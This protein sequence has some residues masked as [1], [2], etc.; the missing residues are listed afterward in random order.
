MTEDSALEVAQAQN[1]ALEA[2]IVRRAAQADAVLTNCIESYINWLNQNPD[3]HPL[4]NLTHHLVSTSVETAA[5]IR[6]RMAIKW[7]GD[8]DEQAKVERSVTNSLRRSAGTNYQALVSYALAR[9]LLQR[10]SH[11]YVMHPVPPTFAHSLA[12]RFGAAIPSGGATGE[13]DGENEIETPD[14]AEAPE[15]AAVTIKPDLDILLRNASWSGSAADSEPVLV[16]SVKT[17]LADRAGAAARW[18][19]YFD[20]VTQP[21]VHASEDECAYRRLSIELAHDPHVRITHGIVTANIY[22]INSDPYY[23]QFGELRSNQA[24]SNTFMF[25]L[26]YTTREESADVMAEGWES[27]TRIEQ[28]LDDTART[29]GM[30]P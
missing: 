20:L 10:Q 19:M 3:K 18:K 12:I 23:A 30:L 14:D 11:W 25:D 27:L 21:C 29:N 1:A 4:W 28:W 15:A 5:A 8:P 9:F 22:K 13:G 26:R 24:R 6:E 16:L 17:S 2:S 7:A